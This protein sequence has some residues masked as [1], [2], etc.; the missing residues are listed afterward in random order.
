MQLYR[1]DDERQVEIYRQD[2]ERQVGISREM[3]RERE[4]EVDLE[5]KKS[6]GLMFTRLLRNPS[7]SGSG[8]GARTVGFLRTRSIS[9]KG[10]GMGSFGVVGENEHG[11]F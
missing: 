6:S 10:K 4:R 8:L 2:E 7:G 5:E 9:G 11:R 3:G 1:R